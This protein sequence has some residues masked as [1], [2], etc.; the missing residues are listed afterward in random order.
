VEQTIYLNCLFFGYAT[1]I[2]T[3]VLYKQIKGPITWNELTRLTKLAQP[4]EL[5]LELRL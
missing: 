5:T 3:T 1:V 2:L 4:S